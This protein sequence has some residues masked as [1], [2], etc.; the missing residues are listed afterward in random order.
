VQVNVAVPC[1]FTVDGT[2]LTEYICGG[3]FAGKTVTYIV[4]L[5]VCLEVLLSAT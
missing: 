2:A 4:L 1:E 5:A 3:K